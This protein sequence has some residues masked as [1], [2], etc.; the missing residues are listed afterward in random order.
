MIKIERD[1]FASVERPRQRSYGRVA[2]M[3]EKGNVQKCSHLTAHRPAVEYGSLGVTLIAFLSQSKIYILS[4]F[5]SS[6]CRAQ[7]L[8]VSMYFFS[9]FLFLSFAS[10]FSPFFQQ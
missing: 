1:G 4:S 7:M 2:D 5:L 10:F 8:R 9:C 3:G 6:I